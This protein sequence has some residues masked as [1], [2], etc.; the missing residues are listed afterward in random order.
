MS[1]TVDS[2]IQAPVSSEIAD[3]VPA[4][5]VFAESTKDEQNENTTTRQTPLL[6]RKSRILRG[7]STEAAIENSVFGPQKVTHLTALQAVILI[8]ARWR[9]KY[10]YAGVYEFARH[11]F[12]VRY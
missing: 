3:A 1:D 4:A 2:E 12:I 11:D 9:E 6:K 10:E 8:Q 5:Y 7:N